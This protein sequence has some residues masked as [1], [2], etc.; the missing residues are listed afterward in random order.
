MRVS[1][2]LLYHLFVAIR[3]DWIPLS[4]R[5]S[6]ISAYRL[7][8][9]GDPRGDQRPARPVTAPVTVYTVGR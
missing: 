4:A 5:H 2:G 8:M 1:T 7:V 6:G 9:R 3:F